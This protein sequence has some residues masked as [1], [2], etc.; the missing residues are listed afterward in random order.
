M[1][2]NEFTITGW[3][4]AI[5]ITLIALVVLS[6]AVMHH[7]DKDANAALTRTAVIE[8]LTPWIVGDKR[9]R[10]EEYRDMAARQIHDAIQQEK[11]G[12]KR[13]PL[14]IE[15]LTVKGVG[16]RVVV[17]VRIVRGEHSMTRYFRLQYNLAL[18]Q[19][20]CEDDLETGHPEQDGFGFLGQFFPRRLVE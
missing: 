4:A 2:N 6:V 10:G 11:T 20:L 18:N 8:E 1:S 16:Y 13:D 7:T 19:W 3:P 15:D 9:Q 5:L 12:E 17:C 14:I